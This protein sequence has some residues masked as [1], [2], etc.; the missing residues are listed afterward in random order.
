MEARRNPTTIALTVLAYVVTTFAV[1]GASHFGI[2]TAHYAAIPIMRTEPVIAMGIASMVIQ[3]LILAMLFPA[4]VGRAATVWDGV[5]FSWTLGAFLA[6]YILGAEAGKYAIPSIP[7]WIAVEGSVAFVQ[8]TL[9]GI[10]LGLI[11]RRRHDA[12]Q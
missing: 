11:H 1:Q 4:V 2:N 6:S 8:Y 10:L 7:S 12:V 9:F 3:G 5:K